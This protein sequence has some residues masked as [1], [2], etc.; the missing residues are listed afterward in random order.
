MLQHL[1]NS[2]VTH[3]G[4]F[5]EERQKLSTTAELGVGIKSSMGSRG[6]KRHRQVLITK[7]C[8]I[9][10]DGGQARAALCEQFDR[11]QQHL[12]PGD[13]VIFA[14]I[15]RDVVAPAVDAWHK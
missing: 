1:T 7:V 12:G 5:V 11:A 13:D 10:L 15:L 8:S 4:M 6:C 14:G 2:V 3:S 9:M